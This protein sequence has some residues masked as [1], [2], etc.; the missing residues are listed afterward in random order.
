MRSLVM[1]SARLIHCWLLAGKL[2]EEQ[3]PTLAT[4]QLRLERGRATFTLRCSR[5]AGVSVVPRGVHEAGL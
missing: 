3:S 2:L 5:A 1:P 4:G